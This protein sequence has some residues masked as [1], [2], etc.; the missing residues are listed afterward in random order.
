VRPRLLGVLRTRLRLEQRFVEGNGDRMGL[1]LRPRFGAPVLLDE[2][3]DWSVK[4]D[5]ELFIALRGTRAGG[6]TGVTGLRTQL[7][8]SHDVSGDLK[9]G[10]AYLR[11]QDF[12]AGGPDSIGHAPIVGI[13]FS[14]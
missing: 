7:G 9:L 14:F 8:L 2:A 6:D 4:G 1:R 3:G 12:E 10:V 11:Q 5:A 13:E